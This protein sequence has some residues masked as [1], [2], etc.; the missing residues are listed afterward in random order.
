MTVETQ[1]QPQSESIE[2]QPG[3]GIATQQD[4]PPPTPQIES[5]SEP[6]QSN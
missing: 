3:A 5:D 4:T 1:S 2:T 6:T